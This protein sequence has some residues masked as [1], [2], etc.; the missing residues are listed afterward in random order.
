MSFAALYALTAGHL[1][2]YPS[3]APYYVYLAESFLQGHTYLV[4]MPPTAY[5]LMRFGGQLYVPG[6]PLPT[7]AFIPFVLLRGT[8]VGFPDAAVTC[9]WGALNV[10]LVYVLLGRL[11]R[12]APITRA[13]RLALTVVFGLGTPFWYVTALGNVWSTAHV[14]AVT[15]V[16]LYAIEVLGQNRPLLAGLWLGLAGLARP[17]CW[18]GFPFALVLLLAESWPQRNLRQMAVKSAAFGA[19]LAACVGVALLYNAARFGSAFDFGYAYVDGAPAL[20]ADQALYGSF[21]LRF[22]PHNLRTMLLGLPLRAERFPWLVPDATGMSI[23]IV[24]PL[25]VYLFKS[26]RRQ[27]LVA[28]AWLAVLSVSLPLALYHNTGAHQFGYRYILD[29]LPIG[30]VLVSTGMDGQ[31]NRW[32]ALLVGASVLVNLAGVLWIYPNATL[33]G[34]PWH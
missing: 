34:E 24:T 16:C 12:W 18:F 17:T 15:F 3:V 23:F 8:P 27:P 22:A 10:T 4:T 20:V 25:L 1:L 2:K 14:C 21:N 11:G 7:L 32:K 33:F 29:W 9:V 31:M 28:A 13:A 19:A 6:G 5:D 30:L 26:I